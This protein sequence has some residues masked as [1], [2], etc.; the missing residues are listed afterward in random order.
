MNVSNKL[1]FIKKET[2]ARDPGA[3]KTMRDAAMQSVTKSIMVSGCKSINTPDTNIKYMDIKENISY[4]FIVSSKETVRNDIG[5]TYN[6]VA[7]ISQGLNGVIMLYIYLG[8]NG[9]GYPLLGL[10]VI[11]KQSNVIWNDGCAP[12]FDGL[13]TRQINDRAAMANQVAVIALKLSKHDYVLEDDLTK[14]FSLRKVL[15]KQRESYNNYVIVDEVPD[16]QRLSVIKYTYE[17]TYINLEEDM[18]T[19]QPFSKFVLD[20]NLNTEGASNLCL[21][22]DDNRLHLYFHPNT[23]NARSA[24]YIDLTQ[25]KYGSPISVTVDDVQGFSIG[26]EYDIHHLVTV[27]NIVARVFVE[28]MYK[29]NRLMPYSINIG[30]STT[31]HIIH[32]VNNTSVH[33]IVKLGT[34]TKR[35]STQGAVS[36]RHASPRE[37]TRIGH[38]R[39]YKSGKVVFVKETIVNEG[40]PGKIHKTY[41]FQK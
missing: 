6:V 14:S 4:Q 8:V 11:D 27:L 21:L 26:E 24:G 15:P 41:D 13:N 25:Y 37:H 38:K 20:I 16:A 10:M 40:A 36:G 3:S 1:S 19:E 23:P 28:F 12:N 30:S 18:L 34:D 31:E 32:V 39:T 7:N 9:N 33:K 2:K 22:L 35:V 29:F 5:I 17:H